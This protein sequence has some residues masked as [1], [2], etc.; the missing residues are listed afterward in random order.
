MATAPWFVLGP[1]TLLS[2]YGLVRGPDRTVPT[3]AED[4][5]KAVVDVVVPCF[6]EEDN[7]VLRSSA[8]RGQFWACCVFGISTNQTLEFQKVAILAKSCSVTHVLV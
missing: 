4:W 7:I 3:P 8:V 2:L 6:R 5:R 1:N